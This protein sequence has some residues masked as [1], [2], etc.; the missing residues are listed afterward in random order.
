MLE[1]W[2]NKNLLPPPVQ[3]CFCAEYIDSRYLKQACTNSVNILSKQSPLHNESALLSR[4][5]YKYDKKFRNDIGYRIFKKINTTL[6]R[7][8]MLNIIRDIENFSSAL[9]DETETDK[10]LPT[11]QMLQYVLVRLVSFSKLML[12]ISVCCKQAAVFYLDRIKRGE[13]H[14]MSLMPYAL[15]SRIWSLSNVLLQHSCGWYA[16]MY[17]FLENLQSKGLPF[18]PDD[19]ELPVNLADW[20]DLKNLENYGRFEWANKEVI[21]V[22]KILIEDSESNTIDSLMMYINEINNDNEQIQ[23]NLHVSEPICERPVHSTEKYV[24]KGEVISR[25]HFKGVDKGEAISREHFK[26][27]DKG[28]AI[29]REHFKGVDKGEAISREHFKGVDKGEAISREHFKGV[30]K[31]E[32]ITRE[33][34]KGVDK[35]EAISRE[36]FKSFFEQPEKKV[37]AKKGAYYH[38]LDRV[39]NTRTLAEFVTNE[40]TYR[41]EQNIMSLTNNLTFMQWQALKTSLLR[42]CEDNLSNNR[43][44]QRKFLQIWKK[45][46]IECS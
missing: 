42:L 36:H 28:E 33:H 26:G 7:Y 38:S 43:K 12:R 37:K 9:P 40:E 35:G 11:R 41:Y 19:Y 15:L 2:N 24:D 25:E 8:L 46:C 30:D 32:A 39:T 1:P 45:K 31:G 5:L 17:P 34:F 20:L 18:L 27:V 6:R 4:F 22:D 44:I 16:Q 3:T 23:T 13:S 10:Y 29:S 14:W 21:N